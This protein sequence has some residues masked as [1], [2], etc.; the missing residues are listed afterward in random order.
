MAIESKAKQEH[1]RRMQKIEEQNLEKQYREQEEAAKYK[2]KKKLEESKFYIRL[3]FVLVMEIIIFAE[4]M[5]F[6]TND[7]SALY[8]L[9]G[10]SATLTTALFGYYSK[11]KAQNTVGGITYEATMAEFT[12]AQQEDM[13]LQDDEA[14]G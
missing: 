10:I 12:Q 9:I 14:V 6:R 4:F 5:M 7:L 1:L 13:D 11:A 2:P 3:M 8:A